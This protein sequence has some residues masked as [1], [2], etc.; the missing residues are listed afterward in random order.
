MSAALK[1]TLET[2]AKSRNKAAVPTLIAALESSD[3]AVHDGALAALVERR[4]KTGHLAVIGRW[5]ELSDGQRQI[6][7]QGRGRIN[8]AL[9]DA[10][11]ADDSR[12]F[13]NGCD[14]I[15]QLTEVDLISALI[16]VA[17]NR[18]SPHAEQATELVMR[19]VDKLSEQLQPTTGEKRTGDASRMRRNALECLERSVDR[20]KQHKRRQLVEAFV[21][22]A[23]ASSDL[24]RSILDSPHHACFPVV[25]QSLTTSG[26]PGVLQLLIDCLQSDDAP[27]VVMQ[28]VGR[29]DDEPFVDRLLAEVADGVSPEMQKNLNRLQSYAWMNSLGKTMHERPDAEQQCI[30]RLASASGISREAL[31]DL[32]EKMLRNGTDE[33]RRV[34]CEA[35]APLTGD[36]P[37]RLIC[38]ALDDV[39]PEVQAEATRQLRDRHVP[40]SMT[41]LLELLDSPHE[42]VRDA[43]REALSEFSFE[44]YLARFETLSDDVRNSTGSLVCKVDTEAMPQ[45]LE[46]LASPMRSQRMRAIKMAEAMGVVGQIAESLVERLKDED[47]LVRALAAEALHRCPQPFVQEAL[48]EALEDKSSAVKAAARDSLATIVQLGGGTYDEMPAEI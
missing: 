9:R 7:H 32:L 42:V 4:S 24:L 12:L 1:K 37:N 36:R 2:L 23:G 6:I 29:R 40:G 46:E 15:E 28:V 30:V 43:A 17:E 18:K 11:V 21:V 35:L 13:A 31:L 33:G 41:R 16:T 47:H 27:R 22:L 44:N 34:A 14:I 38:Q 8:S 26:S 19:L 3:P 39:N 48:E 5:H 20:F 10:V 45:L 25:L